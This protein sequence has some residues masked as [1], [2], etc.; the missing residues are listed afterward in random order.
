MSRLPSGS[1]K[2]C[3]VAS[4]TRVGNRGRITSRSSRPLGFASRRLNSTVN[5]TVA[6]ILADGEGELE[7]TVHEVE[8]PMSPRAGDFRAI[9]RV[10]TR[11]FDGTNEHVWVAADDFQRFVEAVRVLERDRRGEAQLTSLSPDDLELSIRV[12]DRAGH[13]TASGFVGRTSCGSSGEFVTARVGFSFDVD[14]TYLP[15]IVAELESLV[16]AR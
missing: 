10:S 9:V 6:M 14:P 12:R 5:E 3:L 11:G 7:I 13:V 15:G 16:V 2:A 8:P 4:E 1:A